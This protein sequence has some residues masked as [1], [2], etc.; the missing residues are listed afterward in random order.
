MI[1][2]VVLAGDSCLTELTEA[3]G[4]RGSADTGSPSPRVKPAVAYA[5]REACLGD[6]AV[7]PW[8]CTVSPVATTRE[9]TALF[10][11][12]SRGN[13][14]EAADI[15][16]A[17]ADEEERRGHRRAAQMLRGALNPNGRAGPDAH[18][19]EAGS[20][21]ASGLLIDEP[22]VFDLSTVRLRPSARSQLEDFIAE[23]KHADT[24]SQAGIQRRRTMLFTGPPGCGKTM[25]ARALGRELG[26]PTYAARLSAIVGSYLGQTGVHLRTLFR[27]AERQRCV[28]LLD[29]IDSLGQSRGRMEDVGELDRV[30]ISLLQELDHSRPAG[31]TIAATNRPTSLDEALLRR[32]DLQLEFPLPTRRELNALSA[33][34]AKEYGIRMVK[35]ERQRLGVTTTYADVDREIQAL[36]R[37]R[38]IDKV[39]DT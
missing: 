35:A 19:I 26:I 39:R 12:I 2:G 36:R 20:A 3:L 17:M 33:K 11:A 22:A 16:R 4:R 15:A 7:F 24:L 5:I 38:V 32:F 25:T 9:L 37:R 18:F 8:F 1:R 10:I 21:M 31:I 30:V 14:A 34:L 28:L 29:E 27:W 6:W 13:L 23:Y